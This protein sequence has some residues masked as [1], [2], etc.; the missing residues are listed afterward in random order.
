MN[1]R[2]ASE[3]ASVIDGMSAEEQEVY[4]QAK[5]EGRIEGGAAIGI[6]WLL[7]EGISYLIR[8]R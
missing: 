8:R 5:W 4:K 6:A 7:K 2:T 1:W 3:A